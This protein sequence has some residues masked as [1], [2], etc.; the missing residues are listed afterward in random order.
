MANT[1]PFNPQADDI[2]PEMFV[3]SL[4]VDNSKA[5]LVQGVATTLKAGL[6]TRD[7]YLKEDFRQK[8]SAVGEE[9]SAGLSDYRQQ[10]D[11]LLS[12]KD[13]DIVRAAAERMNRIE[14]GLE[15]GK[16]TPSQAKIRRNV[17]LKDAINEHPWLAQEFRAQANLYGGL[18]ST[19][20]GARSSIDNVQDVKDKMTQHIME[21]ALN[22]DV[23]VEVARQHIIQTAQYSAAKQ[24]GDMSLPAISSEITTGAALR[25]MEL[26]NKLRLSAKQ[27]PQGFNMVE[28]QAALAAY[29][30]DYLVEM[31]SLRNDYMNQQGVAF[32]PAEWQKMVN[33]GLSTFDNLKPLIESADPVKAMDRISKSQVFANVQSFRANN[34]SLSYMMDNFGDQFPDMI[35]ILENL[36]TKI[37]SAKGIEQIKKHMEADPKFRLHGSMLLN[38]PVTW[39]LIQVDR[40]SAGESMEND[41]P[42]TQSSRKYLNREQILQAA[43]TGTLDSEKVQPQADFFIHN[44]I[45]NLLKPDML[46]RMISKPDVVTNWTDLAYSQ[47]LSGLSEDIKGGEF[48]STATKLATTI[49][50]LSNSFPDH[51]D[52]GRYKKD[53]QDYVQNNQAPT[54]T[55]NS[56]DGFSVM[57]SNEGI[58]KSSFSLLGKGDTPHHPLDKLNQLYLIKKKY[59]LFKSPKEE[60]AWIQDTLNQVNGVEE[61]TG[62]GED[63]SKPQAEPISNMQMLDQLKQYE[64]ATQVGR[65]S[66]GFW[67]THPDAG[68]E[69]IG[70]GHRITPAEMKSGMINIQGERVSF[71]EGLSDQQ[72]DALFQ[73]DVQ[74]HANAA[75]KIIEKKGLENLPPEIKDVIFQMVYQMGASGV[76]N[77]WPSFFKALKNQD[78][79]KAS[80]IMVNS[81]WAKED[82]PERAQDLAQIVASYAE[83]APQKL[84]PG[85]W[86]INGKLVEI[87]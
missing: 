19:S 4:P 9:E 55:F 75:N 46:E 2:R 65:D 73:Q 70:F 41:D 32:D 86:Y 61:T 31:E 28:A 45:G 56:S 21:F 44:N 80:E 27:N 7:E 17:L 36:A 51:P 33:N 67:T 69:A 43:A 3:G 58:R 63:N 11:L 12:S 79:A 54:L 50:A 71:R 24:I 16:L 29:K 35:P 10:Q 23:P 57:G 78:Y 30:N 72:V 18:S 8:I 84:E 74:K 82:S 48:N 49:E 42:V 47:A 76:A 26:M 37:G 13:Q 53:L 81:K 52:L 25:S 83:E 64:N 77:G 15:E 34:Q 22:N 66:N 14:R 5:N 1:T 60:Q 68:G 6:A 85:T 40:N 20:G 62:K 38:D 39:A 87:K 59:R